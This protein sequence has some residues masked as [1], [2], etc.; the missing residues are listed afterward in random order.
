M[1][2]DDTGKLPASDS[3]PVEAVA[4]KHP[5]GQRQQRRATVGTMYSGYA[6]FMVSR[7]IPT[8][9]GAAMREDAAPDI[10]LEVWG[11][12]LAWGTVGSVVG[13]ESFRRR[14]GGRRPTPQSVTI[15]AISCVPLMLV[16]GVDRAAPTSRVRSCMKTMISCSGRSPLV[17]RAPIRQAPGGRSVARPSD[18]VAT[19]AAQRPSSASSPWA[20]APFHVRELW[21][22]ARRVYVTS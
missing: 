2:D 14:P 21:F 16:S 3:P 8:V 12:I 1:A 15:R 18:L 5:S 6:M 22:A 20:S 10:D 19:S 4:L 17:D 7:M 9:T 13:G 11:R